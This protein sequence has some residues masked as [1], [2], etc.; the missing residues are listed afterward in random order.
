V[1]ETEALERLRALRDSNDPKVQHS[2]ADEILLEFLRSNGYREI[3]DAYDGIVESARW[4][5]CA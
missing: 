4:W 1:T 5:A 2:Q 3:S